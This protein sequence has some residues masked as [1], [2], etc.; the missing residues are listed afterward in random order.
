MAG[1]VIGMGDTRYAYIRHDIIRGRKKSVALDGKMVLTKL[2]RKNLKHTYHLL[3]HSK[4][5]ILHTQCIYVFRTILKTNND[6]FP[7]W[8]F[9]FVMEAYCVFRY[10]GTEVL[11]TI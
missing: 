5:L 9:I 8:Q 11:R 2:V 7:K 3:E 1:H 4:L 6:Y 10:V